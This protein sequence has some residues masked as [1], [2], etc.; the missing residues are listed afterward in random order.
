MSSNESLVIFFIVSEYDSV[1][2]YMMK[3]AFNFDKGVHLILKLSDLNR[4]L[5]IVNSGISIPVF[6]ENKNY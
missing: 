1:F 3:D 5:G 6:K 4:H 2:L